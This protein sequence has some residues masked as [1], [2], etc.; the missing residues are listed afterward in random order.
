MKN[1]NIKNCITEEQYMGFIKA[2]A[3]KGFLAQG[4]AGEADLEKAFHGQGPH[5]E[6]ELSNEMSKGLYRSEEA[7]LGNIPSM[8]H[9]K[10]K[11]GLI[12]DDKFYKNIRAQGIEKG[13][14]AQAHSEKMREDYGDTLGTS[15]KGKTFA[16]RADAIAQKEVDGFAGIADANA[17]HLKDNTLYQ[18]ALYGE[19]SK[20]KSAQAK[21]KKAGSAEKAV[22]IEAG[23]AGFNFDKLIGDVKG[24]RDL[25]PEDIK[26]FFG[27]AI[28]KA[29]E[30]DEQTGGKYH[31]AQ[32]LTNDLKSSGIM[33][34]NGNI[35]GNVDNYVKGASF[36]H[37]RA[38]SSIASI[39]A[40]G[41][42]ITGTLGG[43]KPS[44]KVDAMSSL[45]GGDNSLINDSHTQKKWGNLDMARTFVEKMAKIPGV[46]LNDKEKEA[47]TEQLASNEE[48]AHTLRTGDYGKALSMMGL[49][50]LFKTNDALTPAV[51]TMVG[52]GTLVTSAVDKIKH[53]INGDKIATED[54]MVQDKYGRKMNIAKGDTFNIKDIAP[55]D[56]IR[57]L[58]GSKTEP[59]FAG[60]VIDKTVKT[61]KEVLGK[62]ADKL[63]E[64]M[65]TKRLDNSLDTTNNEADSG[66]NSYT[67][68]SSPDNPHNAPPLNNN[69]T[70]SR[71]DTGKNVKSPA[72]KEAANSIQNVEETEDAIK[73]RKIASGLLD[74]AKF[75]VTAMIDGTPLNPT[76]MGDGEIHPF[77]SFTDNFKNTGISPEFAKSFSTPEQLFNNEQNSQL[78]NY[79][80]SR[81]GISTPSNGISPIAAVATQ[82]PITPHDA[83]QSVTSQINQ[84]AITQNMS[85]AVQNV[86]D[87]FNPVASAYGVT[88][89]TSGRNLGI[90]QNNSG[91]LKINEHL[92]FKRIIFA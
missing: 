80:Q 56:R 21:I 72:K 10:N 59:S 46:H 79:V 47:L 78:M 25:K 12:S 45:K 89:P 32:N 24:K 31:Y 75:A 33:D 53:T 64:S 3:A 15:Y 36:L 91:Y 44:V 82:T 73:G 42:N 68:Q 20:I 38:I 14:L 63:F 92:K 85:Q 40:G 22:D 18:N 34:T 49:Q 52:G 58:D 50:K 4:L 13:D 9:L 90:S 57:A 77:H 1:N 27:E 11:N 6:K 84:A 43:D 76:V 2:G 35:N 60:K 88:I 37:T 69:S 71:N 87:L 83:I 61:G 29:M 16:K 65:G 54:M 23:E 7:N 66:K 74:V 17:N 5:G 86:K 30:L 41:M 55:E 8:A 28:K 39:A 48:F 81:L 70:N 19:E 26:K 51:A 67:D 62:G